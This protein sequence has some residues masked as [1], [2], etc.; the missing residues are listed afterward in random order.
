MERNP[1]YAEEYRSKI[2]NYINKGYARKISKE[3]SDVINN[4]VFYL[5]H[6]GAKNP[7]TLGICLVFDAAIETNNVSLN[8]FLLTGPD[9]N[10]PLLVI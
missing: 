2:Y 8:K 4:N 1:E 9:L 7:H 6:F 5:P 10:Q 3:Q